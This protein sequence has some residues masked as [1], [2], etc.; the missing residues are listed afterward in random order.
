MEAGLQLR[1]HPAAA[2]Q[3]HAREAQDRAAPARALKF[4]QREQ[5]NESSPAT[6]ARSA[7]SCR[8]ACTTPRSA[9][10]SSSAS[11]MPSANRASR[12]WCSTSPTRWCRRRSPLLLG[13]RAVLVVEEGQPEFIEQEAINS[14]CAAPTSTMRT[15]RQGRA[16]DGRRIH[17][18]GDLLNGL[19]KFLGTAMPRPTWPSRRCRWRGGG[20]AA[21]RRAAHAPVPTR[22]PGFCVGCPERPVFSALKLASANSA[23]GAHQRPTSAAIPSPRCEPFNLGNTVL[24]YGLSLAAAPRG[25]TFAKRGRTV[26]R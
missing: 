13:K 1:A 12:C 8:A 6:C 14:A 16:A 19:A 10:C 18:R 17:R 23:A 9:P 22:P 11:P 15:S 21:R 7:S 4:I 5:L 20:E 26:A 25:R 24:G 2:A 3:L